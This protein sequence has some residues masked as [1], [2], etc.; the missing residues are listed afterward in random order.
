M[1]DLVWEVTGRIAA[2]MG[3]LKIATA[4]TQNHKTTLV[5]VK[6]EYTKQFGG[7]F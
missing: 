5:D 7:S 6:A 3:A 4:G 1:N 2:V